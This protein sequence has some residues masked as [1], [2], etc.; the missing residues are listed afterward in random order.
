MVRCMQ[1]EQG[2]RRGRRT[3]KNA[4]AAA[5][6]QDARQTR[7][8]AREQEAKAARE[9]T[10][11]RAR[12]DT[13]AARE[14]NTNADGKQP[15]P[16]SADIMQ[17]ARALANQHTIQRVTRIAEEVIQNHPEWLDEVRGDQEQAVANVYEQLHALFKGFILDMMRLSVA[18]TFP[19]DHMV[20]IVT[21]TEQVDQLIRHRMPEE[22]KNALLERM[23]PAYNSISDM[24]LEEKRLKAELLR[25]M[26]DMVQSVCAT[27]M[28]TMI[29]IRDVLEGTAP[30]QQP[31]PPPPPDATVADPPS[32]NP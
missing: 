32:T 8:A 16:P 5:R 4:T 12:N 9:A 14:T 20:Q 10:L 19:T 22:A 3:V 15:N 29:R 11:S 27:G 6:A 17:R 24:A 1:T 25:V 13:R 21:T 2:V 23:V 28:L 30:A 31:P 18:H 26:Q 7:R